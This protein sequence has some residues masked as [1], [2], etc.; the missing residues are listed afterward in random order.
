ML[1]LVTGVSHCTAVQLYHEL[2]VLVHCLA[3]IMRKIKVPIDS[4]VESHFLA[5]PK[6]SF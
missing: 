4:I 5:F 3:E 1:E 2:D 6:V